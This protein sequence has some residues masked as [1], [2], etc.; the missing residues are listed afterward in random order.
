M[1]QAEGA[2]LSNIG[3]FRS[4]TAQVVVDRLPG[5]E[6][7]HLAKGLQ[8]AALGDALVPARGTLP[9]QGRRIGMRSGALT[10]GLPLMA[11]T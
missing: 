11:L 3:S 5:P 10:G 7:E 2:T 9:S 8:G 4:V 6:H 1:Q